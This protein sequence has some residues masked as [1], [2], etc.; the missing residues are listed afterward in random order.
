[1]DEMQCLTI[2]DLAKKLKVAKSTLFKMLRNGEIP[3]GIRI[4]K[5]RRWRVE[6]VNEWLDAQAQMAGN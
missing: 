2:S 3:T 6:K 4:G 5:C 1:M